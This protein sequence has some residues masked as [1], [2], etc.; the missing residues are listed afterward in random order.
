MGEPRSQLSR[1]LALR[2]LLALL[3]T[4]TTLA[5]VEGS[6]WLVLKT[7][8][9]TTGHV[10]RTEYRLQRPPAYAGASYFSREF[11]LE[12]AVAVRDFKLVPG[13]NYCRLGDVASPHF[14]IE[15]NIRRTTDQPSQARNRVWLFG[16]STMFC[17]EVPDDL[18][19]GSHLQ[20]LVNDAG[21]GIWRVENLGTPSMTIAQHLG[22][23]RDTPVSRGDVVIFYD[24][25][26]D[27]WHGIYN[28]TPE[29]H[30]A[31]PSSLGGVRQLT[32]V[33]KYL[34]QI[35]ARFHERSAA[36]RLL[37]DVE[38][39]VLPKTLVDDATFGQN[40]A[41]VEKIFL[42]ALREAHK[43][44]EERDMRFI[45]LLQPH[46]FSLKRMSANERW[47]ADNELK[48]TPGLDRAFQIGYPRV[49]AACRQA[50][51]EGICTLDISDTFDDRNERGEIFL[52]QC[53]VNHV[54]NHLVA[55]RM[56]ELF[57]PST[58]YRPD[59]TTADAASKVTR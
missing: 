20:R 17:Q 8:A 34:F 50:A 56:F 6:C 29:R 28:G 43:F 27:V 49:Q 15:N 3:A 46:V 5:L 10:P 57:F 44:C 54:G 38:G 40:C 41:A 4:G 19:I 24:G 22:R 31:G 35:H 11:V 23:L 37:C 30:T 47:L 42:K 51:S 52:D 2:A 25:F 45:H 58:E 39:N 7:R 13:T 18:T 1:K 53:H 26:N 9:P 14:H 55:R 21:C 48:L 36:V 32:T 33:Q 12:S 16:G 59:A